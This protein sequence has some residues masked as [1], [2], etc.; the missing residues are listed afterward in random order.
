[1]SCED[2]RPKGLEH[3][4]PAYRRALWVVVILNL[5]MGVAEGIAGFLARSQA[6][7]GEALDFLGDG[8][9]TWLGLA[10]LGWSARQRSQSAFLQGVFQAV[11]GTGVLVGSLYRIFVQRVPT[12]EVMGIV[13]IAG[14]AVNLTA[15][16]VLVPHRHGDANARAVWKLSRNDAIG[17]VAVL[18]AAGLVGLT[19]TPWPDLVVAMVI[20]GLFLESGWSILR[21]SRKELR[22]LAAEA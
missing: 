14:L 5:G 4:T 2:C 9:L 13:A 22:G 15:A 11:L 17:N 1:M 19:Q 21:D 12:A 7:K 18:V 20:S 16:F 6:L 3:A 8:A 10:A